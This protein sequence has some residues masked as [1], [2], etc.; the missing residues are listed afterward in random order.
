MTILWVISNL[1]MKTFFVETW[2]CQMNQH[3]TELIEGQLRQHGLE[4]V[5]AADDA[6]LVILNTC[7]VRDKPVHKIISRIG[8]LAKSNPSTTIG[9]TATKPQKTTFSQGVAA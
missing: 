1:I 7:S 5:S 3:D 6:D 8:S 9:V 2:G 4:P